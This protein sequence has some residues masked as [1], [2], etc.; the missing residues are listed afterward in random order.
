MSVLLALT[1]G[2][3]HLRCLS[4]QWPVQRI[5]VMVVGDGYPVKVVPLALLQIRHAL[6]GDGH[7]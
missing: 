7:A 3:R 2:K 5:H 6:F 4:A 1:S